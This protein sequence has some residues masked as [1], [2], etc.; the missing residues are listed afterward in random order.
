MKKLILAS[1]LGASLLVNSA[2]ADGKA[3][4]KKEKSEKP[5]PE[6]KDLELAG[7]LTSKE[8]VHKNKD[9]NEEKKAIFL[10]NTKEHGAVLVP[11]II[12][13]E[14][15]K[16][17]QYVNKTVSVKAKGYSETKKKEN[18]EEYQAVKIKELVSVTPVAAE[19]GAK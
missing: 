17:D 4:G 1:I 14:D 18:G 8:T 10:L 7:T 3:E 15:A 9:G 13:K 5:K 6:I 12:G 2:Y 19:E 11:S 16:L